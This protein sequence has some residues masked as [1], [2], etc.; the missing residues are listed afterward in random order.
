MV[1]KEIKITNALSPENVQKLSIHHKSGEE[2]VEPPWRQIPLVLMSGPMHGKKER[3]LDKKESLNYKHRNGPQKDSTKGSDGRG[4]LFYK[5]IKSQGLVSSRVS[6]NS[7]SRK[8]GT[9]GRSVWTVEKV[10]F[11]YV[12]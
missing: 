5:P 3:L 12:P 8:S 2:V 1:T 9:N 6:E 11:H 7:G 4:V 10:D